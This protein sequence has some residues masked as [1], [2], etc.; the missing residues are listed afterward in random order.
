MKRFSH[1]HL[2]RLPY[3]WPQ[4][5]VC[6]LPGSYFTRALECQSDL[7]E[8]FKKTLALERIDLKGYYFA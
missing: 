3:P 1:I 6:Q 7:I 8:T 2:H 4:R 5:A